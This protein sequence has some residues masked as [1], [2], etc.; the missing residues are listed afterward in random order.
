[1]ATFYLAVACF[2]LVTMLAGLARVFLGPQQ[3]DRIMAMQLFGTTGV[4]ILLLL[5]EALDAPAV[6][7]VALVFALLAVLAVVAFVRSAGNRRREG[8]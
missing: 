5:A 1:M 7:N 2:L 4:A 3:E 8:D 6:R